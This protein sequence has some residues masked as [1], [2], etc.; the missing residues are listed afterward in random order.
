MTGAMRHQRSLAKGQ[1]VAGAMPLGEQILFQSLLPSSLRMVHCSEER[2]RTGDVRNVSHLLHGERRPQRASVVQRIA[3]PR[4]VAGR[5][6]CRGLSMP[7]PYNETW[8]GEAF[9]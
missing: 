4:T 9:F 8:M 6:V 3:R 5:S 2:I 7:V 1:A